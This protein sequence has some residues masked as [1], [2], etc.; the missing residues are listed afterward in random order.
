MGRGIGRRRE[1]RLPLS[2][3]PDMDPDSR[4]PRSLPELKSDT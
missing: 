1:N 3:E 4:T 2:E